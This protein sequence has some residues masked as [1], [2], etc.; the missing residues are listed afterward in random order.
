MRKLGSSR[1][2]RKLDSR[3]RLRLR[4]KDK[5]LNKK[6]SRRDLPKKLRQRDYE[7]SRSLNKKESNKSAMLR[8]SVR[9]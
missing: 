6:R 8:K 5:G 2:K 3:P 1:S 9:S 7:L 4:Q